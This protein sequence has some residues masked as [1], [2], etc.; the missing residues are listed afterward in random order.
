MSCKKSYYW[1]YLS[2]RRGSRYSSLPNDA[3]MVSISIKM[4]TYDGT[5][6]LTSVDATAAASR[7]GSAR[8]PIINS[9]DV[10]R[11]T[12]KIIRFLFQ[13]IKYI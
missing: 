5:D 9:L 2:L 1:C 8:R 10:I 13:Y 6:E 4:Y 3:R 7:R 12:I 11:K